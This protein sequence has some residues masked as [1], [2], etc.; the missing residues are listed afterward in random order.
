MNRIALLLAGSNLSEREIRKE[1]DAFLALSEADSMAVV[2]RLRELDL[3]AVGIDESSDEK[4]T[5]SIS[6]KHGSSVG[7]QVSYLL[8]D[9]LGLTSGE[10]GKLLHDA[11]SKRMPRTMSEALI[12]TRKEAFSTWVERLTRYISPSEILHETAKLRN[13]LVH[14]PRSDWPLDSKK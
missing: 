10:A 8:R 5:R 7:E 11:L 1:I 12:F 4:P 2:K 3:A 14:T 13:S 6:A 9:D